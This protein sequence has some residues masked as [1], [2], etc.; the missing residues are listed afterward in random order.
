MNPARKVHRQLYAFSLPKADVPIKM[1]FTLHPVGSLRT[2]PTQ[3]AQIKNRKCYA[4]EVEHARV[5]AANPKISHFW[6]VVGHRTPDLGGDG[7]CS[8]R[9]FPRRERFTSS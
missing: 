2:M 4:F 7:L 6:I 8:T 3:Q 9:Q 5:L 1:I